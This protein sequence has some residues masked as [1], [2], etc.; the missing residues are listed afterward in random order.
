MG[1]EYSIFAFLFS[2]YYSFHFYLIHRD[3]VLSGTRCRTSHQQ[4]HKKDL[5]VLND[6]EIFRIMVYA[7]WHNSNRQNL[8]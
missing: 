4:N 7:T 5:A 2:G 3:S 1:T 6:G 8:R